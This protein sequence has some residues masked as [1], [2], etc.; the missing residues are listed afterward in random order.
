MLLANE[1]PEH[2]PLRLA[3]QGVSIQARA[4]VTLG[5]AGE[6]TEDSVQCYILALCMTLCFEYFVYK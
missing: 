5:P 3:V 2:S 6:W 4:G 1:C